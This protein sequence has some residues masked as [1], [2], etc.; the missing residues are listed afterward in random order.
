M[1]LRP[2][3]AALDTSDRMLLYYFESRDLL[4]A[5]I[6]TRAAEGLVAALPRIDPVTPPKSARVWIDGC[7]TVFADPTA[8]PAMALLFEL[9]ALAVRTAGPLRNAT[10]AVTHTWIAEVVGVLAALRVPTRG[11]HSLARVVAASLIGLMLEALTAT[12]LARPTPEL[13][14]LAALIDGQRQR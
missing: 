13:A 9:D 6:A 5:A 1:S 7:W 10:Q 4:V 2:L 12:E 3:A 11:R 14:I 8:R